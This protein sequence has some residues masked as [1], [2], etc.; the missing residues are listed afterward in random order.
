MDLKISGKNALITGGTKGIGR[1][2]TSNLANHGVNVAFCARTEQDVLRTVNELSQPSSQVM[3]SV[4]DVSNPSELKQWMSESIKALGSLDILILNAAGMAPGNTEKSWQINVEMNLL[5]AVY[6]TYYAKPYLR[7]AAEQKGDASIIYISSISASEAY[8]EDAYGPI[9]AALIHFAKG[10]SMSNGQAG[11]RS[12]VISPGPVE[13]EGGYWQQVEKND[14]TQ[15]AAVK[16]RTS[17]KRLVKAEEVANLAT[18]LVS[19]L[20]SGIT[21]ANLVIDCGF[22]NKVSF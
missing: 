3:G 15:F 4:A 20:A 22:L 2:I 12:N 8:G 7:E 13:C 14:P 5:S 16:E 1:A 11:I 10:I 9:K 6:A 21:G 18:F 19:P 17:L